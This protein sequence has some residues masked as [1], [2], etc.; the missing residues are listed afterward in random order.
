MLSSGAD[1]KAHALPILSRAACSEYGRAAMWVLL[2]NR[3]INWA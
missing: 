2:S 3:Q 1:I